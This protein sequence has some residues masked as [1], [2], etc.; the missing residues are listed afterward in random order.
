MVRFI[1]KFDILGPN[2]QP[3]P[4]DAVFEEV[5]HQL[6]V[7]ATVLIKSLVSYWF[8]SPSPILAD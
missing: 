2:A 8:P 1:L 5:R 6:K 3:Y 7:P 4:Y